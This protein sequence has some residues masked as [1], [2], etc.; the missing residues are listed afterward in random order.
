M[1]NLGP[2]DMKLCDKKI[3]IKRC[4]HAAGG[5][6]DIDCNLRQTAIR[7]YVLNIIKM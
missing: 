6:V 7:Q 3:K 1:R 2:A 5:E 4:A